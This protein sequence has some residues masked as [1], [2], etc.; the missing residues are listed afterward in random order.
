MNFTTAA[1]QQRRWNVAQQCQDVGIPPSAV[2][3]RQDA[4]VAVV[5]GPS[6]S[7]AREVEA[8]GSAVHGV[9]A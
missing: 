7:G 6:A 2:A 1:G 5:L 9:Q 8:F 3:Q 4:S